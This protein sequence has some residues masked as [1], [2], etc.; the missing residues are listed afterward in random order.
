MSDGEI[1]VVSSCGVKDNLVHMGVEVVQTHIV[2]CPYSNLF[3]EHSVLGWY[4]PWTPDGRLLQPTNLSSQHD[5]YVRQGR[6]LKWC[7][8]EADLDPLYL[9]N[10]EPKGLPD[11]KK[12]EK[13]W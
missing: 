13:P 3:G 4:H 11:D 12:P 8:R 9:D 1:S 5:K 10:A 7:H 6:K 2:P